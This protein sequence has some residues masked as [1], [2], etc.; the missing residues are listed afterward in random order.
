MHRSD[1]DDRCVEIDK[2]LGRPATMRDL[3]ESA[4]RIKLDPAKTTPF[5]VAIHRAFLGD[6]C[7]QRGQALEALVDARRAAIERSVNG[8]GT[9]Y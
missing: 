9:G 2:E 1:L 5:D 3:D 6:E 4:R 8:P 7:V